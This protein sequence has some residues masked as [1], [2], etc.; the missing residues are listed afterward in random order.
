RARVFREAQK[1]I[2]ARENLMAIVS[3]DL[4]N[5]LATIL[6]SAELLLRSVPNDRRRRDRKY[7]ETVHRSAVR[8]DRL[9]RDLLDF[10][11]VE[12]GRLVI[13]P[14]AHSA[15]ELVLEALE[16]Q[17]HLAL[18]RS[19]RLELIE[20]AEDTAVLCDRERVQQVFANLLGNALKFTP[21]DGSITLRIGL[22]DG[23]VCFSVTDTG[24]GIPRHELPHIF[25]RFWQARGTAR[26]G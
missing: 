24:P 12:G 17:E 26:L 7:A 10:A 21:R 11:T 5:P 8:M 4:R 19:V 25:E 6:M 20:E 15:K 2:A 3:H 9:V 16:A 22:K 14:K 18:E 1:A 13:D 23:E